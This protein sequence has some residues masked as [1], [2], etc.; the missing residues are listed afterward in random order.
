MIEEKLINE[1]EVDESKIDE[2]NK[3]KNKSVSKDDRDFFIDLI[4]VLSCLGVISIHY[5]AFYGSS[6]ICVIRP[7]VSF[8][9]V[10]FMSV[11]GYY[12]LY[13]KNY[14]YGE[15]LKRYFLKY[16]V[17]FLVW[18]TIYNVRAYYLSDKSVSLFRYFVINSEGWHLWYLKAYLQILIVY[19]IAKAITKEKNVAFLFSIGWLLFYSIKYTLA[20]WGP[21]DNVYLRVIQLPFF[22]YNGFVG[23]T[24]KGYTPMECLGVFIL[25]GF[26]LNYIVGANK[27]VRCSVLLIAIIS[28]IIT[29]CKT[30]SIYTGEAYQLDLTCDPFMTNIIIYSFGVITLCYSISE[31]IP[32]L[33]RKIFSLLSTCTLSVYII[34]PLIASLLSRML[35][36]AGIVGWKYKI[37][38]FVGCTFLSFTISF[39][40]NRI[41]PR[42]ISRYILG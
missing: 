31:I 6:I 8:S 25:G 37:C 32:N 39:I 40:L 24:N 34:H 4:K 2:K 22:Q 11:S 26:F 5:S 33:I 23:G 19:P 13:K 18:S 28:L 20:I 29:I 35:I 9:V 30:F 38:I 16:L 3:Q 36:F 17:V 14:S 7:I 10:C 27:K 42:K 12:L 1:I 15:V 41:I 21:I